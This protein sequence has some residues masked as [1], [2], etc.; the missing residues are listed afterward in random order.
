[1]VGTGTVEKTLLLIKPDA[2]KAQHIGEILARI[3]RAGFA[4][5]GLVLRR[6]DPAGAGDFYAIHRDKEFFA[7]LVEFMTS[8]PLV[9]VRLEAA[10]ARAHLREFVGATDPA[11]AAP[12]TI[13]ADFGTAVRTNAVHASNPAED[14]ERELAFFFPEG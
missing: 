8:G 4:V 14:V 11:K 1:M 6:L 2:V 5:T 9:A 10:G 12:G 3:E 7:G 13:R